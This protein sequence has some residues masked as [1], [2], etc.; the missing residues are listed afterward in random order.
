[1]VL[2]SNSH[3]CC[4]DIGSV[5]HGSIAAAWFIHKHFMGYT[6]SLVQSSWDCKHKSAAVAFLVETAGRASAW[7]QVNR[8]D[9]QECQ[10]KFPAVPLSSKWRS[11]KIIKC[12]TA[13]SIKQAKLSLSSESCFS[14]HHT[15]NQPESLEATRH[16]T[17]SFLVHFSL[18]SP[19]KWSSNTGPIHICR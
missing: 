2:W 15:A 10:D 12:C 3:L 6:S 1:M 11:V 17:Q 18:W 9:Q 5:V 13:S 8:R 4:Q 16:T 14:W 7:K 19:D